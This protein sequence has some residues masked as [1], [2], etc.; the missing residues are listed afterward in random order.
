[1][2]EGIL[3]SVGKQITGRSLFRVRVIDTP[4]VD[5]KACAT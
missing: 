3:W 2:V 1:M 4:K 5:G